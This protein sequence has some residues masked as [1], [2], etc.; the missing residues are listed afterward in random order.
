MHD[1]AFRPPVTDNE[2][3]GDVV[4]DLRAAVAVARASQK[5]ADED[6]ARVKELLIQARLADEKK[7]GPK[8]LERLTGNYLDRATISRITSPALAARAAA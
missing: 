5:R 1:L 7:Y 2:D 8:V 6:H 4:E 3:V